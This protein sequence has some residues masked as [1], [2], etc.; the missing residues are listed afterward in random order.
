M[1]TPD[2]T[3]K[4]MLPA[5]T[6][7]MASVNFAKGVT[8]IIA[9]LSQGDMWYDSSDSALKFKTDADIINV[10]GYVGELR[11][12]AG[13]PSYYIGWLPCLGQEISKTQYQRLYNCIGDTWGTAT[14]N[15]KFKLPNFRKR[16]IVGYDTTD[17]NFSIGKYGGAS[18]VTLTTGN[19][20]PHDHANGAY[21][22]LMTVDGTN[23]MGSTGTDASTNEVNLYKQATIASVGSSTP[24]ST[25]NPYGAACIMIKY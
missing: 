12:F 19:L 21:N 1:I 16:S 22:K 9:S 5:S 13:Q 15:T 2:L 24:F 10:G 6:A 4:L 17:T 7:N 18:S 14:D 20:P 25:Q 23:T 3:T 8:P 11:S